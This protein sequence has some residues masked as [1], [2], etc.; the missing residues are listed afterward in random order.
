MLIPVDPTDVIT[1]TPW[2]NPE[3]SGLIKKTHTHTQADLPKKER[4]YDQTL[5]MVI[6]F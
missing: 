6:P 3:L 2:N 1:F 4:R 5:F